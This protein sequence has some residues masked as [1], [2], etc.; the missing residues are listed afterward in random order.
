[1]SPEK[2]PENPLAEK[3]GTKPGP[4]KRD[5][6]QDP[7]PCEEGPGLVAYLLTIGS[8]LLVMLSLPLSLFFVV[9]VVQV[10]II[11]RESSS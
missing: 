10:L 2:E 8:L 3:N 4:V 7:I 1:M 6:S 5:K 9:K 11:S